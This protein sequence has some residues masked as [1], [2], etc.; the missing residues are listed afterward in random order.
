[1]ELTNPPR[2]PAPHNSTMSAT[3]THRAY[4]PASIVVAA[5]EPTG[6]PRRTWQQVRRGK[7]GLHRAGW[8]LT[9]TRGDPRESATESRPPPRDSGFG[10]DRAAGEGETVG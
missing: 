4:S 3:P 10:S 5:D 9:A 8:L 2:R 7:S 1:M 6:R